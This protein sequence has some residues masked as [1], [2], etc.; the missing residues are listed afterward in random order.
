MSLELTLNEKITLLVMLD[1]RIEQLEKL[2]EFSR[3][4]DDKYLSKSYTKDVQN[5]LKLKYKIKEYD[6]WKT[7]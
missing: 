3:N 5:L 6:T 1:T 4:D 2:V 7:I